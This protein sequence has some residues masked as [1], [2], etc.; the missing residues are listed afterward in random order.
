M[1]VRHLPPPRPKWAATGSHE[2]SWEDTRLRDLRRRVAEY[3]RALVGGVDLSAHLIQA[4]QLMGLAGAMRP[5]Y[6]LR[7][8]PAEMSY[9]WQV[10]L[11][12]RA[13]D[14]LISRYGPDA[15]AKDVWDALTASESRGASE[16]A[17]DAAGTTGDTSDPAQER[18]SAGDDASDGGASGESSSGGTPE[19]GDDAQQQAEQ[20]DD[21]GADEVTASGMDSGADAAP[22]GGSDHRQEDADASASLGADD[23]SD[24]RAEAGEGAGDQP[25]DQTETG[26]VAGDDAGEEA[27]G[28]TGEEA[29]GETG[30]VAG[31]QPDDQTEDGEG[32]GED[33]ED[34]EGAGY[35]EQEGGRVAKVAPSLA[36]ISEV[37]RIARALSRLMADATRPEPSPLWDGKRVVREMITR[38]VRLH[39]MRRDIP[40]VKGLLVLYD[41][42]G[43]CEWIAART[44]GIAEALAKRYGG[45][46]AAQT[47]AYGPGDAEGSL[48]PSKIVGR[49]AMRFAKLPPIVGYG[50][51]V[52]GWARVKA[53]GISH[54][55]VFGDAHGTA[56]YRAAAK[57]GI[58]VLWANPNSDIAPYDT[59]WCDYTLITDDDIAA[60]VENLTR[61]T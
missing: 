21:R 10:D 52:D 29:D 51:D 16:S 36:R 55:L 9:Y 18:E 2:W 32:A 57:A 46:Y 33:D 30:E 40:A 15:S 24:D 38:Q 54:V 31:D 14:M 50:A 25:D 3:R 1:T 20:G 23:Q 45:F 49:S 22:R 5:I 27:D 13:L 6:D 43:S 28:E 7:D 37:A 35:G 58:R 48:D 8:I 39:R 56:G 4:Q 44:W 11:A 26:E 42:S 19:S 34:G 61:R 41:V 60:A 47:P 17:R 53:A 12:E 59:S